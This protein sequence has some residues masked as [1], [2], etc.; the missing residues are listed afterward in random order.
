[1]TCTGNA[2]PSISYS[3]SPI[4]VQAT[5]PVAILQRR[6]ITCTVHNPLAILQR[7]SMTCIGNTPRH[8]LQLLSRECTGN[9]T[10]SISYSGSLKCVQATQPVDRHLKA[11]ITCIVYNPS[12][13]YSVY[14]DYIAHTCLLYYS[15]SL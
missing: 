15:G 2:T 4:R 14:Y 3:G 1:M 13:S 11:A 12:I 6:S 8:T 9:T 5:Q 10:P 7:L